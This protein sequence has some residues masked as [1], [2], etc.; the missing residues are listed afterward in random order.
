[1]AAPSFAGLGKELVG[2]DVPEPKAGE[3][4]SRIEKKQITIVHA[5]V[6]LYIYIY[7]HDTLYYKVSK[8]PP[9]DIS[10]GSRMGIA[11]NSRPLTLP[12]CRPLEV[13]VPR[14]SCGIL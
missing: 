14:V 11:R 6:C 10:H 4:Q 13:L 8:I 2:H 7:T 9:G 5:Y 1:M 3:G 12:H